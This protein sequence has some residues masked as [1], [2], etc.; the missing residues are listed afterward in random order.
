MGRKKI[1]ILGP[2]WPY[3][4]GLAA[5][6]ERLAEELQKDA[7]VEI[8]TFTLQ[9]PKFLFPGKSQYAT[10]AAPAHLNIT[11][12]INSINPLNWLKLGRQIRKMKPDLIIAKYWLPLMGPALGSLIRLGKRGNTKAFSILDN[13][14]PHEKRPGDVAFT[15]YFLK[16]VDA[17]IAMSQSVL[18]D[19]KVFEPNKPVSLIPHPIYD[20]YGMPISKAAARAV[21]NLDAS[22]KYIL[23][24]GFIRQY[25]GLDLLMQAMADERMKKLDVHLIV[26]GEYYEDAAPYN[27]LLA[28]LQ[29]GDRILM[30]TDFIPND[31]VKNYFCAADLVVQPYKSAT[32][33]GISQIAYHF[34]KPMVVTR[35]G[36][37]LEMVPDSVVGYQCEPDPADIAAKIEQY[38]LEN[39]EADMTA[40]VH[41][42]KQKYSWDRLAKEILRLTGL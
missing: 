22:K 38:Y 10:E 16:P 29:L 2:A 5:Y 12:K 20:N 37:L 36:G 42:E 7:D 9:Y 8:W 4:G 30:H 28:K 11:R 33:S 34:E 13:V 3:R 23:F 40:A 6:N 21:L 1:L 31:A 25:K 39:R 14:V 24:F 26:A 35:V 32:Q 27:E 18:D 41:V 15:K 17:F 19:L